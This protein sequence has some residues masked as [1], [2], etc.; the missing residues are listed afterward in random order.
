MELQAAEKSFIGNNPD[1]AIAQYMYEPIFFKYYEPGLR[2]RIHRKKKS[3][4][5]NLGLRSDF[6]DQYVR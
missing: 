2:R 5:Q 4:A 6:D 1:S 3:K